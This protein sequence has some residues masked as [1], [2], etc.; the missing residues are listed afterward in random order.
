MKIVKVLRFVFLAVLLVLA[1]AACAPARAGF[2]ELPEDVRV[3]IGA[4][5][6]AVV[7]WLL[8]RLIALVPALAWLDNYRLPAAAGLTAVLIDFI[9]NSVPDAYGQVAILAIQLVLALLAIFIT[10][11]K[12]RERGNRLF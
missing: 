6:L 2:V 4:L 1:L 12:L 11:E 3:G 10:F 7:S 8:V 9:Q 5:V